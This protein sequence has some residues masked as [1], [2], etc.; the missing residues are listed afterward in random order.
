MRTLP[1]L[2]PDSPQLTFEGL[3]NHDTHLSHNSTYFSL[4]KILKN[5]FN[6]YFSCDTSGQVI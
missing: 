3:T 5:L 1:G 6:K 2:S 4:V